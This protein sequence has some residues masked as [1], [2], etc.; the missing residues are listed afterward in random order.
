MEP[1]RQA[2]VEGGLDRAPRGRAG[3]AEWEVPRWVAE[4]ARKGHAGGGHD[5]Q[6]AA[7]QGPT[8]QGGEP[9]EAY[10]AARPPRAA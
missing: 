2:E 7:G 8:A 3:R 4:H 6:W 5:R 10:T 1:G 9:W